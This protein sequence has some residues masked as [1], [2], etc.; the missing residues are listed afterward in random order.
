MVYGGPQS[1][2]TGYVD[3]LRL[4]V[5]KK[6]YVN[7]ATKCFI[8]EDESFYK[9]V[10]LEM[11][12]GLKENPNEHCLK[13]NNKM[14]VELVSN[15]TFPICGS[16]NSKDMIN[17][18]DVVFEKTMKKC[19]SSCSTY[20]YYGKKASLNQMESGK[21][22][23]LWFMFETMEM[24]IRQEYIIYDHIGLISSVGGTLGL[25]IGFSFYDALCWFLERIQQWLK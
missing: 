11:V 12:N 25:F 16:A 7:D 3:L 14:I 24:T 22:L 19:Q 10:G 5:S 21:S 20:E 1:V 8:K 15:E 17:I 4:Q 6:L 23:Q 2:K 18:I 9:C 13:I